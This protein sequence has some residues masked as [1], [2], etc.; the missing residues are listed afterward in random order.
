MQVI[1]LFTT[2]KQEQTAVSVSSTFCDTNRGQ[3]QMNCRQ[4]RHHLP[5]QHLQ[6]RQRHQQF[7]IFETGVRDGAPEATAC[8]F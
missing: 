8:Y 7:P 4:S 5:G 3:K 1:A 6:T 2:Q